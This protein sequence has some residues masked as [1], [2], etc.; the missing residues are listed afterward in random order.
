MILSLNCDEVER[1]K[2]IGGCNRFMWVAMGF[3]A[4]RRWF[5][6]FVSVAQRTDMHRRRSALNTRRPCL[7]E[8]LSM[9]YMYSYLSITDTLISG[10]AG[11]DL[12]DMK[13]KWA[14][15]KL[16]VN[17]QALRPQSGRTFDDKLTAK[18]LLWRPPQRG[19]HSITI[20]ITIT[21]TASLIKT[22]THRLLL[23]A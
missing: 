5:W 21:I 23:C 10:A 12:Q 11:G 13:V 7:G 9:V 6:Q 4:A 18:S 8:A 3:T 1:G 22:L 20:T 17:P 2:L 15:D 19:T 16:P 14:A